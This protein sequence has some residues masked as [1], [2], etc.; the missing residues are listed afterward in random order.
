MAEALLISLD[1]YLRSTYSLPMPQ[2][3]QPTAPMPMPYR[4]PPVIKPYF[5]PRPWLVFLP[6]SPAFPIFPSRV[7]HFNLHSWVFFTPLPPPS[8]ALV[9]CSPPKS[10]AQSPSGAPHRHLSH[11]SPETR[12]GQQRSSASFSVRIQPSCAFDW[13]HFSA[14]LTRQTGFPL[15]RTP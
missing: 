7:Y 1:H 15:L 3:P 13:G 5:P 14:L 10:P 4:L 11:G 6:F 12:L 2:S 9:P 8:L